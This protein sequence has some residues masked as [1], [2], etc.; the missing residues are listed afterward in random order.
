MQAG[1]KPSGG[2]WSLFLWPTVGRTNATKT[3]TLKLMMLMWAFARAWCKSLARLL[4][5]DIWPQLATPS[6]GTSPPLPSSLFLPRQV[7][8]T[9]N[10]ERPLPIK[11][12]CW[13]QGWLPLAFTQSSGYKPQRVWQF[14][15]EPNTTGMNA[16]TALI[17]GV[18]TYLLS[19][20]G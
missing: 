14:R 3:A 16:H 17:S 7:Q 6:C 12:Y 20:M 19:S 11:Q 10:S 18:P 13:N 9:L 15:H 2:H 8:A 1:L 4:T 5:W